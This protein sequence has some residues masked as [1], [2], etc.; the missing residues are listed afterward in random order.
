QHTHQQQYQQQQ[1]GCRCGRNQR[2]GHQLVQQG[3]LRTLLL[4]LFGNH[5]RNAVA[6]G[7]GF[8][9]FTGSNGFC[10]FFCGRCSA[11]FN[12]TFSNSTFSAGFC[13]RSC[14]IEINRGRLSST[15][16]GCCTSGFG[17][18]NRRSGL[19]SC[20]LLRYLHTRQLVIFQADQTLQGINL[21]FQRFQTFA[22]L[23][24]FTTTLVNIFQRN[25]EII[26]QCL[27]TIRAQSTSNFTAGS[28]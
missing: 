27:L 8:C 6:T 3:R 23:F 26:F 16:F 13:R 1:Q 7:F 11:I 14:V 28:G 17:F 4:F 20:L 9:C 24:V 10:T 19:S 21:F 22:Q 5:G 25:G 2:V 15:L 12:S 18:V